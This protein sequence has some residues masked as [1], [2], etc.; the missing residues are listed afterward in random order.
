MRRGRHGSPAAR[1]VALLA[2]A[3]L[4]ACA[5]P[6]PVAAPVPAAD[7]TVFVGRAGDGAV[8][9][10]LHAGRATAFV[11]DGAGVGT[12]FDGTADAGV[13]DLRGADGAELVG[14][15]HGQ[16]LHGAVAP[17]AGR[18][19]SFGAVV[20]RAP[21]GLYVADARD[22]AGRAG[23][24][25]LADGTVLGAADVGGAVHPAPALDGADARF[26]PPRPV[27]GGDVPAR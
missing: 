2:L 5:G 27:A 26:A 19:W 15:V 9:I 1:A 8:A 18:R 11:T 14:A 16:V 3:A 22:G 21:A 25:R 24:I 6:A 23:W 12:W 10:A 20:A 17:V 4:A 13:V 7:R